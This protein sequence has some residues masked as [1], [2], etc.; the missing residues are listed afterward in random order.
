MHRAPWR[1]EC[2]RKC[3]PSRAPLCTVVHR[4]RHVHRGGMFDPGHVRFIEVPSPGV[5]CGGGN[6]YRGGMFDPGYVRFIEVPSP[7]AAW[8]AGNGYRGGMF[9]PGNVRVI[10]VPSP[11]VAGGRGN[12]YLTF[13]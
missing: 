10:Q 1:S 2:W 12:G 4:A 7:G 5:A 8:G 13:V 11:G 6:G 9:D 3:A